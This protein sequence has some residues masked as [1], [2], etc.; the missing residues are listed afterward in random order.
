[1]KKLIIALIVLFTVHTIKAQ[2]TEETD[3]IPYQNTLPTIDNS[4]TVKTADGRTFKIEG[5]KDTATTIFFLVRHAEKDTTAGVDADL[6]GT[7]RGRAE[8]LVKIFKKIKISGV[9]STSTPRTRHT[10]EP[11]AKF[12]RR[13][14]DIYDVK[15]QDEL[16]KKLIARGGGR[17]YF[18]VGHSNTVPKLALQI[19]G[20][21]KTAENIPESEY[22][23]LYIVSAK[24]MGRAKVEIINF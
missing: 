18:I 14:V 13:P 8:A 1:M 11:L 16:V 5:F 20:G 3:F 17:R 4:G 10:A 12:K 6:I 24:K 21:N 15:K 7:G 9:Y 22:S 2:K 23:R 19:L